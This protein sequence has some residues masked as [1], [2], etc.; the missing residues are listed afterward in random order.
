[1]VAARCNPPADPFR[2]VAKAGQDRESARFARRGMTGMDT[3]GASHG[4]A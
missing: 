2:A 4:G 1:M 3:G